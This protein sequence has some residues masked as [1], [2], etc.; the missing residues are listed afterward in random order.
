MGIVEPKIEDVSEQ[1]EV[2]HLMGHQ[3]KFKECLDPAPFPGIGPQVK[4]R[5]GDESN[6]ML[7]VGRTFGTRNSCHENGGPSPKR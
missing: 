5:V 4:M 3:E 6:G 7:A 1:N 2:V